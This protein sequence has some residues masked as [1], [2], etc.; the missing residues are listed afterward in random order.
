MSDLTHRIEAL[1]LA[2]AAAPRIMNVNQQLQLAQIHATL[3]MADALREVM[4]WGE[5]ILPAPFRRRRAPQ[6]PRTH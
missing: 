2:D 4:A 6:T 3:D 5:T 1:A